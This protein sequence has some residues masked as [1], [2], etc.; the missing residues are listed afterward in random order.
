MVA[1]GSGRISYAGRLG[2]YG[3]LVKIKHADGI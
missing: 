2:S 3:K 1:A